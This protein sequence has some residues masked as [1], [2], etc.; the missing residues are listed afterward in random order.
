MVAV[1][2]FI[3]DC[4]LDEQ[5]AARFVEQGIDSVDDL[6]YERDLDTLLEDVGG[7]RRRR[8]DVS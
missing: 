8:A 5:Y 1:R 2:D 7:A 4:G 6:R 3:V